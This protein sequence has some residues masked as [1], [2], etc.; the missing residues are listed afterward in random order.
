[1]KNKIKF[2]EQTEHS[3]CGLA[4]VVMILNYVG[5][6][7]TLNEI[8]DLFGVPRGGLSLYHL[9]QIVE[10]Y[11]VI[12]KAYEVLET[13]SL[14]AI[15]KPFICLWER[16]HYV[17]VKKIKRSS[18]I[19][20][21]PAVG[22]RKLS[23]DEFNISF[24]GYILVVDETQY[25]CKHEKVKNVLLEKIKL[26][27]DNHKLKLLFLFGLMLLIQLNNLVMPMLMQQ[28]IDGGKATSIFT[29]FGISILF[30]ISIFVYTFIIENLK[31]S[32][33]NKIQFEFSK[34]LTSIFINKIV[35]LD[36][37]Y[38]INRTSGDWI[39]RA[40]LVEYIQQLLTPEL[41]FSLIDML[42]AV[43]YFCIMLSYSLE[44]TI[45]VALTSM[46]FVGISILNTKMMFNMN[47]KEL[48][49][50]SR[51]QNIIVEFFEGIETIKSL[52][53]ENEFGKRWRESFLNNKT[54]TI[55]R[56]KQVLLLIVL[57]REEVLYIL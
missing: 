53:M 2:V 47:A 12:C 27:L 41:L 22:K 56:I 15:D 57:Y 28:F 25:L 20:F 29:N 44:L 16:N 51:V 50:Q 31:G 21:D 7:L 52:K 39:Y 23:R 24:S 18:V 6:N 8:R 26:F 46:F 17:V 9:L 36:F 33:I 10:H 38:F 40:R 11:G 49:L 34:N 5:V 54:L 14:Q 43:I 48:I 4:C 37:K 1:M 45:V 42:F 13:K 3:E 55:K 19:I 32:I 35:G 30:I